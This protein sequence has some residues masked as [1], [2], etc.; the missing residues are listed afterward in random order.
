LFVGLFVLWM[1]IMANIYADA[2]KKKLIKSIYATRI[3]LRMAWRNNLLFHLKVKKE[4]N[5]SLNSLHIRPFRSIRNL[6]TSFFYL[7]S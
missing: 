5:K 6:K 2:K 7:L 3:L 1:V 4:L